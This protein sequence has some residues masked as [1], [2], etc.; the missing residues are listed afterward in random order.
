MKRKKRKNQNSKKKKIVMLLSNPLKPDP[1][2]SNE[3]EAL[4]KAGYSVEVLAWDREGKSKKK[5]TK[6][7]VDINR[8]RYKSTYGQGKK[9][10][11]YF[12]SF[13]GII[14]KELLKKEFDAVHCHDFDTLMGGF[15]GGKIRRKKVIYDAHES[16]PSM[17]VD[18][19]LKKIAKKIDKAETRIVKRID[20]V[21]TV[22]PI[23]EK[24]FKKKGAKK[25]VQ[26]LNSKDLKK[27]EATEKE[28]ENIRKKW[29]ASGK[30]VFIYIGTLS[31]KRNLLELVEIFKK[32]KNAKLV[33][34]GEGVLEK[35]IKQKIKETNN[36]LFIGKVSEKRVP[37]YTLSSD[38][39]L[40]IYKSNSLNNNI[41]GPPNKLFEAIAAGKPIITSKKGSTGKMVKEL[42]VGLVVN[43]NNV[44]EI[45]KTI[46]KITNKQ[47]I[48][49]KISKKSKEARK[50]YNWDTEKQKLIEIYDN[51]LK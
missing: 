3:A 49:E 24:I 15:I 42:E 19:G 18:R 7:G 11:K 21:I 17:M 50:K 48:I 4:V 26:I 40:A 10:L 8:I 1:R 31:P 41:A 6:N 5:E 39:V 43:A 36:V 33:I 45:K 2:V 51:L 29:K 27:Y 9:Q 13:Q 44:K 20:Q 12:I 35:E 28:I 23:L 38:V 47:K 34:G 14:V 32:E 37:L 22:N 46:D 30:K 25:I 16:Y